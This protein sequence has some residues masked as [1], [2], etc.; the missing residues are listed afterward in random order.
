METPY[1][2]PRTRLAWAA[3][4]IV[5]AGYGAFLIVTALRLPPVG[6]PQGSSSAAR[7]CRLLQLLK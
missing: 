3:A 2:R 7:L 1:A 6:L 4:A 5:G